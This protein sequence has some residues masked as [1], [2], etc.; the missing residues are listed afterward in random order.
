VRLLVSVL[1]ASVGGCA[2]LRNDTVMQGN[3]NGVVVNFVGDVA[4][5]LS[6]AQQFCARYER[7]PVL[8]E[9][10]QENAYYFCVKPA[11][12]PHPTS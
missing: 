7:I 2:P 12:A 9:T 1:A 8:H 10:K 11:D 5:T 3:A 6:L 4:Q